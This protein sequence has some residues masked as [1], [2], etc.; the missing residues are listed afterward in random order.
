MIIRVVTL[1]KDTLILF[2]GPH[3]IMEPVR[4]IEMLLPGNGDFH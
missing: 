1:P 2:I 3:W 4:C